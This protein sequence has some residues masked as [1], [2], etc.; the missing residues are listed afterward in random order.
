MDFCFSPLQPELMSEENGGRVYLAD[1][2]LNVSWVVQTSGR[3]WHQIGKS[4]VLKVV[5]ERK[6]D[7]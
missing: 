2:L 4:R 3:R 5:F 6:V 7:L 1:K